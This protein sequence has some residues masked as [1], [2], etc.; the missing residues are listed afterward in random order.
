MING[1]PFR[2][3]VDSGATRSFIDE[4]LRLRPPLTFIGAYFSLE[5]VNG[6]TIVSTRVAP[7]VL[8]S[9]SKIQFRSCLI[10]VPIMNGFD[11]ILGKDWL[12]LVKPLVDWHS[13]TQL[14]YD[15]EISSI[16]C[17]GS[18]LQR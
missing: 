4:K 14:S 10:V 17:Q 11:L 18:L 5:I 8:V 3:L 13:N 7:Y 16:L 1:T 6:E 2:A 15:L 12:D 9:I